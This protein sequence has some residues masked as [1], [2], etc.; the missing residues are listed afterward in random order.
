MDYV[1]NN[2]TSEL[3]VNWSIRALVDPGAYYGLVTDLSKD[4]FCTIRI[5][6]LLLPQYF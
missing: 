6:K 4:N 3:F 1:D 2:F 5:A